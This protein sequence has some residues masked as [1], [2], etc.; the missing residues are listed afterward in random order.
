ME[1]RVASPLDAG[2]R[3]RM[4]ERLLTLLAE[5]SYHYRPEK[6]FTLASG[7]T[8]PFCLD[9]RVTTWDPEPKPLIGAVP[10]MALFTRT[11]LDRRVLG[12]RGGARP[13]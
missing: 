2:E 8:S 12:D 13:A 6:P 1:E 4:P 9:A 11:D 7:A 3:A 5:R 10:C